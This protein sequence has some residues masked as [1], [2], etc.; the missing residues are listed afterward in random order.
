MALCSVV[1]VPVLR[2]VPDPGSITPDKGTVGKEHIR[3]SWFSSLTIS[4]SR[5]P[6]PFAHCSTHWSHV[7]RSSMN[8]H[9]CVQSNTIMTSICGSAVLVGKKGG[10]KAE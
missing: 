6:S 7:C 1:D 5:E 4:T 9:G 10:N 3:R 8:V 2:N